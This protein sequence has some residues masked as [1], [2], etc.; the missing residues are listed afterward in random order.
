MRRSKRSTI[1][2]CLAVVVAIVAASGPARARPQLSI[3]RGANVLLRQTFNTSRSVYVEVGDA[4]VAYEH[5]PSRLFPVPEDL[6]VEITETRIATSGLEVRFRHVSLGEGAITASLRRV[7]RPMEAAEAIL[8]SAFKVTGEADEYMPIVANRETQVAHFLGSNHLPPPDTRVT[9]EDLSAAQADGLRPCTVCFVTAPRVSNYHVERLLGD[10]MQSVVRAYYPPVQD[11]DLQRRVEAAG[12][13]VLNSWPLPLK[14]YPYKFEVV[15]GDVISAF[16]CPGGH[17]FATTGLLD[18]IEDEGELEAALAQEIAHIE[19]RHGFRQLRSGANEQA[20]ASIAPE[21]GRGAETGNIAEIASLLRQI[22]VEVVL[23]GHSLENEMEADSLTISY[24]QANPAFGTT[25]ALDRVL[26]KQ[27]YSAEVLGFAGGET[28][29]IASHPNIADRIAR[30]EASMAAFFENTVFSGYDGN[31]NLV[32]TVRFVMQ[33]VS[34]A[35]GWRGLELLASVDTTPYLGDRAAI[36]GIEVVAGD[37]P[38]QLQSREST[39][40]WPADQAGLVFKSNTEDSLI[41]AISDISFALLNVAR[42]ELEEITEPPAEPEAEPEQIVTA[43]EQ[44]TP[45]PAR[46]E[47]TQP[48]PVEA[49][50]PPVTGGGTAPRA[51]SVPPE[52]VVPVPLTPDMTKPE[53]I[54]ESVSI[55][56]IDPELARYN[57]A[58]KSITIRCLVNTDGRVVAAKVF[59]IDPPLELRVAQD[60]LINSVER[61]AVDIW[62][63]RPATKNGVPVPVWFMVTF[64]YE[65][66]GEE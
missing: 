19:M 22:A 64:R 24:L 57:V 17:V 54:A 52:D 31:G 39:E 11:Q 38:V 49:Q 56:L 5:A 48:P 63:F 65:T 50:G 60:M 51:A 41:A 55:V 43:R 16:G 25:E 42:W 6:P 40:V 27:R 12:F 53:L 21:A 29:A 13:Q 18:A 45:P 8:A 37:R 14:G 4:I 62:R 46:Q 7:A 3:E 9:F 59:R 26:R 23:S 35:R 33:S 44:I 61:S 36:T 10:E 15:E 30:A 47:E 58:G 66:V 2:L 20:W 34:S 1:A 28:S 32:A